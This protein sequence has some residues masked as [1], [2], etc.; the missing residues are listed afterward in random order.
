MN[1]KR[2]M[3]TDAYHISSGTCFDVAHPHRAPIVILTGS[4][5]REP[6]QAVRTNSSR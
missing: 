6:S 2:P 1:S 5:S 4:R 3:E